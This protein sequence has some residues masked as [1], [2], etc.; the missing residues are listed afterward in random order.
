MSKTF[1]RSFGKYNSKSFHSKYLASHLFFPSNFVFLPIQL[2]FSSLSTNCHKKMYVN[3]IIHRIQI[4]YMYKDICCNMVYISLQKEK[5][6]Y[7]GLGKDT[8]CYTY[9]GNQYPATKK[10]LGRLC[11][12]MEDV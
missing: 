3:K 1:Y 10:N 12:N 7:N 11:D 4:H 5:P 9:T 6:K 8:L 2:F